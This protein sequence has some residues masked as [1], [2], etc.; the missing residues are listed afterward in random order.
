VAAEAPR[1]VVLVYHRIAPQRHRADRRLFGIENGTPADLFEAHIRFASKHFTP[2]RAAA[3]PPTRPG[4]HFAVTFDDGYKDVLRLAAP[5]LE[6]YGI[7]GTVFVNTDFLGTDRRFWWEQ[8]GALLRTT[9]ARKLDIAEAAPELRARWEMPRELPLGDFQRRERAHWLLSMALMRTPPGEIDGILERLSRTLGAP[10]QREGRD[11]PLL[12]WDEAREL[13]RRGIELGAHGASHANLGLLA[14]EEFER[15]IE[16]SVEEI[17]AQIDAPVETFAYPY[18]GPEHRTPAAA[19][20]IARS[21]CRV[22]FTT[23]AGTVGTESDPWNLPRRGLGRAAACLC[24]QRIDA[25]L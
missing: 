3:L 8:L 18:G 16:G 1:A 10:L 23:D 17:A 21:G 9:G 4:F 6:R 12:D 19:S 7:P 11:F 25:V 5:I 15:E 20:A 13:R 14:N 22:A 2:I 24:A